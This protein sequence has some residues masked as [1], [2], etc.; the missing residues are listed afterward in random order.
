MLALLS[1][2]SAAVLPVLF[3][4]L[5]FLYRKPG[6]GVNI[7]LPVVAMIPMA[8]VLGFYLYM[9]S[10]S[11]LAQQ[12]LISFNALVYNLPVLPEEFF[13]FFVPGCFAVLP[14][15]N[16]MVTAGGIALMFVTGIAVFILRKKTDERLLVTGVCIF[17]LPLLAVLFYKPVFAGFAYDYLDHRMLLP[18]TG[19]LLVVYALVLP[20]ARKFSSKYVLPGLAVVMAVAAVFNAGNYKSKYTYYDNAVKCSPGSGLAWLNYGTLLNTDGRYDEAADKF[21]HLV[22]LIPDN[23]TFRVDLAETYL[24]KKDTQAM[25]REYRALIKKIPGYTDAYYRIAGYYN[26]KNLT[27]SAIGILTAAISADPTNARNYFERGK[28]YYLK[29]NMIPQAVSD[30]KRSIELDPG[31]QG[32]YF[33]LG[34]IYVSQ[35]D[36]NAAYLNYDKY[37]HLNPSDGVGIFYRGQ[38]LCAMGRSDEGCKDLGTAAAMGIDQARNMQARLCK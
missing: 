26:M 4:L 31:K 24:A 15:F 17:L 13:K 3:V 34:S 2:E 14:A 11:V 36:Y 37:V 22:A 6:E 1:K 35:G 30:F 16:P 21:V 33:E 27:D 32:P 7:S 20:F 18:S 12:H 29:A 25:L 19:L 10:S 28:S 9:R 8:L 23:A 5:Y 38:A